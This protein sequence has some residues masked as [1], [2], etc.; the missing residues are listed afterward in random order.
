MCGFVLVVM[1][2]KVLGY[3]SAFV[4]TIAGGHRPAEL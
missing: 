4:L 3:G 1:M 2:T